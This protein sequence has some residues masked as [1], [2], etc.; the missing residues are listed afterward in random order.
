MFT[1]FESDSSF[2]TIMLWFSNL[3][4]NIRRSKNT[5]KPRKPPKTLSVTI[6]NFLRYSLFFNICSTSKNVDSINMK[7]VKNDKKS[8]KKKAP[9]NIF[10]KYTERSL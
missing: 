10:D 5:V 4:K 9:E 7:I 2:S 6:I 8:T 3:T 1:I